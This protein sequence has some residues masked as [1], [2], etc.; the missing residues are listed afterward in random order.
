ML[1]QLEDGQRPQSDTGLLRLLQEAAS[2]LDEGEDET[3]EAAADD[4]APDTEVLEIFLEEAGEILDQL[5]QLLADWRQEPESQHF[6]QEAQRALHTLKGGARLSRQPV[7]RDQSHDFETLLTDLGDQP[8]AAD[9]WKKI[10]EHHDGLIASVAKV[11]QE[12]DSYLA[13]QPS[14]APAEPAAVETDQPATTPVADTAPAAQPPQPARRASEQNRKG[15]APGAPGTPPPLPGFYAAGD[16]T[17]HPQ[18][19]YVAAAGGSRAAI[20]MTEGEAKLDLSAM[21]GVMF[22]DPQVATV[23]L[24]EA[25]AVARGYSVDT[26]LLDLENVPRAL[27]NFDT[28]GFIKM[29]AERNSGR[30][31]GVQIVAAEGGEIIQTAV[32]ALRAGLTVQEI[33]DDLFPYLTMVEALKL[34][35]QTFTKDVKQLSCCA[36]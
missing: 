17:I 14:A 3:P 20:N 2:H 18:F 24:S 30:L 10:T 16:C 6:S 5:E 34:C 8:P 25:E 31:L 11:R 13:G 28:Q 23:G 32:M 1:D 26:R 19:G 33:G 9:D 27:V 7:L 4:D 36:G 29:V 12:F 35:A 15:R 21:P 22:T